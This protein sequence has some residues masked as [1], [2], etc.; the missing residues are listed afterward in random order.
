MLTPRASSDGSE[1]VALRLVT[2]WG[3]ETYH[4]FELR[5]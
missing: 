1:T 3:Y 4:N 5:P 2:E